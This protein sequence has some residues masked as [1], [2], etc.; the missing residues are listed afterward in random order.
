M[1][2]H[3]SAKCH[4][5]NEPLV[6]ASPEPVLCRICTAEYIRNFLR[7]LIVCIGFWLSEWAFHHC[8]EC[9]KVL[10]SEI[11]QRRKCSHPQLV[12]CQV[13]DIGRAVA[14]KVDSRPVD[15]L[16]L[17][18]DDQCPSARKSVPLLL[19]P[20]AHIALLSYTLTQQRQRQLSYNKG[21]YI[22]K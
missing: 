4:E 13:F 3:V 20:V 10:F 15:Q 14:G 11:R 16:P 12:S 1:S 2:K 22:A 9:S 17:Q 8:N 19:R 7:K 21:W 18:R 6:F 5:P